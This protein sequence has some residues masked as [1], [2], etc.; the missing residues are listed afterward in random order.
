MGSF[1]PSANSN[2]NGLGAGF[3]RRALQLENQQTG[4]STT[5]NDLAEQQTDTPEQTSNSSS[6]RQTA[7]ERVQQDRK[8]SGKETIETGRQKDASV[9]GEGFV[10]L[11]TGGNQEFARSVSLEVDSQGNV[12]DDISGGQIQR[13]TTNEN[14]ETKTEDFQLSESQRTIEASATSEAQFSGNI[15][16]S[17]AQSE[18]TT[19]EA[20][21]TD[22]SDNTETVTLEATRTAENEVELSAADTSGQSADFQA[23]VTFNNEGNVESSQVSENSQGVQG[24]SVTTQSGETVDVNQENIDLSNLTLSEGDTSAEAET[25]GNQSGQLESVSVN[26]EGQLQGQFS[27]GQTRNFGEVATAQFENPSG[28]TENS[29]GTFNSTVESGEANFSADSEFTTGELES[30]NRQNSQNIVSDL[31]SEAP[32][33]QRS[34]VLGNALDLFG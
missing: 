23:T 31:L 34:E 22:S 16:E 20:E 17:L 14:G 7:F 27:N 6:D 11:N 28:L 18:S 24:L 8:S 15:S 19:F 2:S 21:I 4:E 9:Q 1:I 26:Q 25:D 10:A 5:V 12:R 32:Q 3:L 29:S 33:S 30:Q 13:E